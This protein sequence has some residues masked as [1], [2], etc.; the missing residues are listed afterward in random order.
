ME[1][2]LSFAVLTAVALF[3]RLLLNNL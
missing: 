3:F 2:T 1:I